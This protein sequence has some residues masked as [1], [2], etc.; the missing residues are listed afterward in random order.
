MKSPVSFPALV[1]AALLL[2]AVHKPLSAQEL[3]FGCLGLVGGFAGYSSQGVHTD[4]LNEFVRQY[5][6]MYADSLYQGMDQFGNL[7]GFRVGVNLLRQNLEGMILTFKV[8]YENLIERKTAII[9]ASSQQENTFAELATKNYGIGIDIGTELTRSFSVKIIDAT[10]VFSQVRFTESLHD[11]SGQIINYVYTAEDAPIGVTLGAGFIFELID[12]YVSIEGSA[13]YMFLE[14]GRMKTNEGRFLTKGPR[15]DET[16]RYII[17]S[18]GFN[19]TLQLNI[20][21][22]L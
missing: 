12:D 3:G 5:N 9:L 15:S 20:G 4:E 2:I 6:R 13:G 18:G 7:K 19:A 1:T 8:F 10:I 14:A 16:M 17:N 11:P 22:T 21:V